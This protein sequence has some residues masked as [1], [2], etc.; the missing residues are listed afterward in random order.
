MTED[1]TGIKLEDFYERRKLSGASI[2]DKLSALKSAIPMGE[3]KFEAQP[4]PNDL[5]KIYETIYVV[6]VEKRDALLESRDSYLVL[7]RKAL[8]FDEVPQGTSLEDFYKSRNVVESTPEQKLAA[9]GKVVKLGDVCPGSKDYSVKEM[10][11]IY[12]F[13]YNVGISGSIKTKPASES[14]FKQG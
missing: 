5:L 1:L 12:E 9:L 6:A 7:L 4:A 2:E 8:E 3:I 11:Q 13:G 14:D 10:L